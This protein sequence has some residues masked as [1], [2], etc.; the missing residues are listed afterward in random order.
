MEDLGVLGFEIIQHLKNK[1]SIVV[2]D[3]KTNLYFK[4]LNSIN[5]VI[6]GENI[7]SNLFNEDLDK[8][9]NNYKPENKIK[10]KDINNEIKNIFNR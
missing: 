7:I 2:V 6:K 8:E 5:H 4:K 9:N 3:V 1:Y 10:S